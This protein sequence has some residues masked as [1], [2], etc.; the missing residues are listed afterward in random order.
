MTKK[1]NNCTTTPADTDEGGFEWMNADFHP[2]P[3][4]KTRA[5]MHPNEIADERL[6]SYCELNSVCYVVQSVILRL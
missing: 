2:Y 1:H 4:V 5:N 6:S 3:S